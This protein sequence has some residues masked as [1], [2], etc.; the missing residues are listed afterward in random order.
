MQGKKTECNNDFS[1][2]PASCLLKVFDQGIPIHKLFSIA[3]IKR[4]VSRLKS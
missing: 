4:S 1:S 2:F 3:N